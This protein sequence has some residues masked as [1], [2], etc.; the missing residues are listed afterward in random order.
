MSAAFDADC[1]VHE[2]GFLASPNSLNLEYDHH[3]SDDAAFPFPPTDL[4]DINEYL[5]EDVNVFSTLNEQQQQQQQYPDDCAAAD[6]SLLNPETLNSPEDP[7]LQPHSGA[8]TYGCDDGGIA[9][10]V[11]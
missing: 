1:Y 7:I 4:F 6:S 10:G 8:S 3:S 5:N 9:V 11:I 2:S